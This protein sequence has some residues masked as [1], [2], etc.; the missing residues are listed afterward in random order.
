MRP[1]GLKVGEFYLLDLDEYRVSFWIVGTWGDQVITG[2]R[3]VNAPVEGT[4]L[5]RIPTEVQDRII[6]ENWKAFFPG[7]A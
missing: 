6:Y 5:P 4:K 2:L 1:E 3:N 7:W